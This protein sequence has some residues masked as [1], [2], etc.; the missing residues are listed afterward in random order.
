MYNLTLNRDRGG[1]T[2]A[3]VLP[4][5]EYSGPRHQKSEYRGLALRHRSLSPRAAVLSPAAAAHQKGKGQGYRSNPVPMDRLEAKASW[6]DAHKVTASLPDR[7]EL[8][9]DP[10]LKLH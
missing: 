8:S 4:C 1:A 2:F 5:S 9:L 3:H 7:A 10:H 6:M